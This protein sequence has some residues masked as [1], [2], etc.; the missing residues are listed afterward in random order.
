[1]PDG[2]WAP[3]FDSINGN[4]SS[5]ACT[6]DTTSTQVN[7]KI[8]LVKR[9]GCD[10]IIKINHVKEA[11][12]IGVIVYDDRD[13]PFSASI[14]VKNGTLPI[15]FISRQD[16][17]LLFKSYHMS[18]RITFKSHQGIQF[19]KSPFSTAVSSFSSVGPSADLTFKP[20]IAG[21]GQLIYSTIPQYMGSWGIK[22]GTS[23]ACPYV[24]GAIALYLQYH[25]NTTSRNVM[26][27]LFQNYAFLG[28]V[29]NTTSGYLDN[30]VRQG[31]GLIQGI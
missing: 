22:Q 14:L 20:N 24:A 25:G 11:G 2:Y 8:A 17:I 18:S 4:L 13:G 29:D 27:A 6:S 10:F 16:G 23:M 1:M 3:T 21:V 12:G 26:H 7:G 5:D 9:G 19:F 30:P 31:A 28:N 15:V